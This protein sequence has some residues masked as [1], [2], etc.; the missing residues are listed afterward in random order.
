[1][2]NTLQ[3]MGISGIYHSTIKT[4]YDKPTAGIMLNR[5]NLKTFLLYSHRYKT[6][7]HNLSNLIQHSFGA[8]KKQSESKLEE[9]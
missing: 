2:I 3:S 5:K 8:K 7:I 9:K 4:I 6:R 1:M